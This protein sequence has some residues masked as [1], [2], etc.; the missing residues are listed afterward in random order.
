MKKK[1]L[2]LA[3]CASTLMPVS[4]WGEETTFEAVTEATQIEESEV[5][6]VQDTVTIA[7]DTDVLDYPGR[8]EG[9][10]IGEVLAEDEVNRTGTISDT[11]SR[12]VFEDG[13]GEE[14][15][16]YVPNSILKGYEEESASDGAV[17]AGIIHKR[18]GTGIFADAV[19]GVTQTGGDQGILVGDV[20][21][22]SAD[23]SLRPLGTFRITHY[24]PCSICCGPWANG[25]TSTGSTAVTNGASA[26]DPT[27]IP[28]GSR[29]VVNGQV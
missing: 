3:L 7:E 24:C 5:T 10:V 18:S 12:I 11:W 22:A 29:V 16:G 1:I 6:A 8:K 14:Q 25:V 2:I 19:E 15:T 17:E 26:V 21:M 4:A 20:V 9:N 28:Y 13:N 27:G 23:S